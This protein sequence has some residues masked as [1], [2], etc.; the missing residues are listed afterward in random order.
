M[1][2]DPIGNSTWSDLWVVVKLIRSTI[3]VWVLK[4][5][6]HQS[7]VINITIILPHHR[8]HCYHHY[9]TPITIIFVTIIIA[10]VPS[11][12]YHHYYYLKVE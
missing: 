7:F 9:S 2:G 1:H 10:L 8:H 5:L 12:L 11:L 6:H 4:H 3:L